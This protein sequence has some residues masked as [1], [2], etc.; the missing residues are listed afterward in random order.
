MEKKKK[1]RKKK[2]EE[3]LMVFRKT[4]R[5]YWLEY[6]C[7]FFLLALLGL[8]YA[9]EVKIPGKLEYLAL[10]LGFF[11][12]GYI[13]ISRLLH[14]CVV[15]PSKLMVMDG[16]IKRNKKHIYMSSISDIDVKQGLMQRLLNYGNIHIKCA[17]GEGAAEI[18]D[19]ANPG[20]IME[21]IE[22]LI[23]KYKNK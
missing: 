8:L 19:V 12:I 20:G 9:K 18:K 6:G 22:E 13:E 11:F 3:V 1:E 7:A 23:E 4:R 21:E 5:S 10:G 2:E 15:L 16:L 14:K 17:S